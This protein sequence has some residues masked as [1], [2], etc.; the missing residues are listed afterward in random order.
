MTFPTIRK[1]AANFDLLRELDGGTIDKTL[2]VIP[3][4]NRRSIVLKTILITGANGRVGSALVKYVDSL[5]EKYTLRLADLEILDKRG[6]KIDI[7]DLSSCRRACEDVDTVIHLAGIA[8]PE[9]PFEEILP[10]NIVGTYNIFQAASEAGVRRIVYASSAQAIEGYPLDIQVKTDMPV[11]PKN[12]YGVSKACGEALA[13]YYAYQ[14]KLEAIAVRIGAFE[15]QEEWSQM[16]SRDLSA[17]AEPQDICSLIV[18]CIETDLTESPFIIAHGI[19]NNRFKRLDLSDTIDRL[20]YTP[21]ADSFLAWNIA[22]HKNS[23]PN[24]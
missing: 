16:S 22:L 2:L 6:M 21:K 15:Y 19:S 8:S 9:S 18:R 4:E 17:W 10:I 1:V 20:G 14:K 12:L 5:E 13:A 7:T 11:R 3:T 23:K 24:V